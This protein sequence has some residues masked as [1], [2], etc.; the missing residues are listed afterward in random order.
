MP[1]AACAVD[2]R[3]LGIRYNLNLTRRTTLKGSLAEWVGRKQQ[4]GRHF[5]ALRHVNFQI[6]HGES[7]GIL[8]ANGAGKSTLLLALA[9]ILAPDEGSIAVSGRVSSLL[10]LGAGFEMEISG[11]ENIF[12]IGGFM[13]IRHRVMQ[14]LSPSIIEFAN[15][16]AFIDAP[17]RTYSTGMRARLGFAIATAIAPD[18]LLLDEVLG[19][20]DEEFRGRSRQRIREMVAHAKAIVLVT[21]DL[22]T[23]TEFCNRALLM[24]FGQVV[25]VGAP[26]ET[27]DFYR[28]RV[29]ERKRRLAEAAQ[30]PLA[31]I[32]PPAVLSPPAVLP[33][34]VVLDQPAS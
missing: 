28:D 33:P 8:G 18:I 12:L 4:V 22:T 32:P 20:G 15:I 14:G 3:D 21:H 31:P 9:G 10:T 27:V 5:W 24:E 29:Q 23:V 6:Q 26:Q 30:E 13:G 34:P 2:V 25:Y 11:R 17:V 1:P 19:T 16:G 7:L